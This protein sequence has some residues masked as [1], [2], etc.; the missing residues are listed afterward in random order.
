MVKLTEVQ[1]LGKESDS[2]LRADV[3]KPGH[4]VLHVVRKARKAIFKGFKV[5]GSHI[6]K[7]LR[8]GSLVPTIV[9]TPQ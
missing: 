8:A 4:Q 2:Q 6:E 1:H 5:S 7:L 9:S 3:R